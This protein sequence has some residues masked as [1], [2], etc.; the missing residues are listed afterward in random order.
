MK[1]EIYLDTSVPNAYLD[2][3]KPERQQE[4]IEF[5]KRL[6]QY[7]VYIS[8]FVI[9]EIQQTQH[10]QRRSDLL[11]LVESF[12]V[13]SSEREEI[14]TLTQSYVM[15]GSIAIAEDALHV[16]IAVAHKIG[17]LTSWNYRHLVKLKTKRAVNALNLLNGYNTIEII[18]PSML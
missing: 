15:S 7:Q 13:L 9:T 4:T 12:D 2:G 14:Q 16:A 11:K 6:D 18:D 5:W 17:I 3:T 8:D 10:T 1:I